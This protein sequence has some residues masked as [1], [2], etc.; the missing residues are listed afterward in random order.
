MGQ[1]VTPAEAIAVLSSLDPGVDF[2]VRLELSTARS[3]GERRSAGSSTER[4]RAFRAR[5]SARHETPN[6]TLCNAVKRVSV[7]G[8]QK[9]V[10]S[11]DLFSK[12]AEIT[13]E[14]KRAERVQV[15]GERAAVAGIETMK[16]VSVSS[17]ARPARWRRVPADWEPTLEHRALARDL[18]VDF[19]LELAK[20]RDFE[21][22]SPKS[23]AGATFRNWLRNA[24]P[25]GSMALNGRPGYRA[26][27]SSDA[28]LAAAIARANQL[29]AEEAALKGKAA[30]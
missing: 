9:G 4:V 8:G 13:E 5:V 2:D 15:S 25:S 22:G 16:R 23:D 11:G 14:P 26:G 20:F 19:G 27:N 18:C 24:K 28:A 1:A 12:G 6:E 10:S 21:F 30:E 3:K 17:K 7:S 29:E